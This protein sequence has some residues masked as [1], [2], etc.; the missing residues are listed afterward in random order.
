M[1]NPPNL[2]YCKIIGNFKAFVADSS[3]E[4]GDLDDLPDFLPMSGSGTITPNVS[5]AKNTDVNNKST[6]FGEAIPVTVD[7]DGDL[8]QGENKYVMVL[9]PSDPI[10]PADF[11]YSVELSLTIQDRTDI[12]FYGPYSFLVIPG[13]TV[14]LTDIIPVPSSA[15]TVISQGPVGPA[16]AIGPVGPAG[17]SVPIKGTVATSA[18]LPTSGNVIGDGWIAADTGNLWSYSGT[19][20]LDLGP[21]R[22]PK[23]DTGAQGATGPQGAT[24]ADGLT[25]LTG[26]TGPEGAKG[27]MGTS[28]NIKGSVASEGSLPIS[29]MA[30]SDAWIAADT[31]I[32][33]VYDGTVFIETGPVQGA[34]GETGPQGAEGAEGVEGPQG[35]QGPAGPE[36]AIGPVG[37]AGEIGPAGPIG[38]DGPIGPS[39][40]PVGPEG[41]AGPAGPAGPQGPVGDDGGIGP[42]GPEGP[43]GPTGL[44]GPATT[45]SVGTVGSGT[46][47]EVTVDGA[48]PNQVIN[49]VLPKGDPG[50]WVVGTVL[51]DVSLDTIITPGLFRTT[52]PTFATTANKYPLTGANGTCAL[53]V[54]LHSTGAILQRFNPV[55]GVASGKVIYQRTLFSG[56][57]TPWHAFN[58]TRTDQTAGRAIYQWDDLNNREQL[59]YGDTGWRN[60]APLLVDGTI[61][62]NGLN[63]RRVGYW[64]DITV[65]AWKPGKTGPS[66]LLAELPNGFRTINTREIVAR[67]GTSIVHPQM[68]YLLSGI[69]VNSA[70]ATN[71]VSFTY[72]FSTRDQWP[73]TLPGT[74]V[75]TIPN[76]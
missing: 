35:P 40:G 15:G 34:K 68:D 74:A 29:G 12:R 23:G 37:P 25:G 26:L 49:F 44:D 36:G 71:A 17:P 70:D 76:L 1:A 22:G 61:V 3:G 51:G 73:T 55:F 21:V 41:P 13:G 63:I 28:I 53:E 10:I 16:G 54:Q 57:W 45:L 32:L 47:A 38:N 46:I 33:Y 75:G 11:T 65:N 60:I 14:D 5:I 30:E 72:G 9:T 4:L 67:Q 52:N 59:I 48:A 69:T 31:G 20:F 8:S 50:G 19:V 39:G 64:V 42:I 43:I 24:G 2:S 7:I 18:N 27:D 66:A 56:A 58:S 62:G 6:L